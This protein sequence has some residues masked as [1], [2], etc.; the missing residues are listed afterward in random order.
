MD[1]QIATIINKLFI[2][3]SWRDDVR[4]QILMAWFETE[5]D[6]T[7]QHGEILSYAMN[8]AYFAASEWRRT[9]ITPVA[10]PRAGTGEEPASVSYEGMLDEKGLEPVSRSENT[11][12]T[13]MQSEFVVEYVLEDDLEDEE[14][15]CDEF[16]AHTINLP[17]DHHPNVSISFEHFIVLL[18]EGLDV[19]EI[20]AVAGTTERSIYR[21]L[22]RLKG[23]NHYAE[24]Q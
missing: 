4:Q 15:H 19:S 22:A 11:T 3:K 7:R 24:Y 12:N 1:R 18:S 14:P 13:F 8:C 10:L 2:P 6:Q 5:Y 16:T 21:R 23:V 17:K 9:V 20:G